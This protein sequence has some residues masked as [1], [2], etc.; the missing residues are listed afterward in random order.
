MDGSGDG[1]SGKVTVTY[2]GNMETDGSESK[3]ILAQ[4]VGGFIGDTGDTTGLVALGTGDRSSGDGGAVSVSLTSATIRTGQTTSSGI[5]AQSVGGGG[6]K[7]S[8]KADSFDTL[9]TTSS[10][11]G[12]NG[13]TVDVGLT[14]SSITTVGQLSPG[15][16]A[17][18]IGGGGGS[19]GTG[20]VVASNDFDASLNL[21]MGGS[22]GKGS[23]GGDVIVVNIGS[24]TTASRTDVTTGDNSAAIIAQSIGGGGGNGGK[25]I[26]AD[27]SIATF[28]ASFGGSGSEAGTSGNVSVTNGDDAT[29]T[30]SGTYAYGIL[31]QSVAG[32]GGNGGSVVNV[33][34]DAGEFSGTVTLTMGGKG[35]T[36]GTSQNVDVTNAGQVNTSGFAAMGIVAQAIGGDG[37]SGRHRDFGRGLPV[38]RG[39]RQ[40]AI[41]FWR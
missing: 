18:S 24:V 35:G 27:V 19:S 4:S 13:G 39:L 29:L 17:S 30:T 1:D 33:A 9:G 36:G 28:Q 7:G 40:R 12:G 16:S 6:G 14:G 32:D 5:E 11:A 21:T 41:Q 8:S 15:I 34:A 31:A 23:A 2:Q 25:V 20:T 3:G 10:E 37:G 26:D 38:V 22:G